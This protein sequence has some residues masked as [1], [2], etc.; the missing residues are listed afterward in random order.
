MHFFSIVIPIYNEKE[1]IFSLIEEIN[2]NLDS[3]TYNYEILIINDCSSDLNEN[4]YKIFDELKN[5]KIFS[6]QTNLGQSYSLIS[7]IK[8]SNNNT[9]L[10]L[11]GDG[12]NN[13]IDIPKL[14]NLYFSNNQIY[15]VGGIRNK[16]K[17]SLTKLLASK[18]ANKFRKSILNDKCDDTGCALKIFD[19]KTFLKFP[20]FDG[21]HRFLPAFFLAYKKK[22]VYINVD[23]RPRLKGTSKYGIYKRLINGLRDLYKVKKIIKRLK[24]ND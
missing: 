12:Q 22:S 11:D 10:T 5:T 7:G 18:I 1:N 20:E 13:P 2:Q 3:E 8:K 14:V 9:I 23:H 21:L 6:N 15:M 17:D 16:R 4:D 19:K 24:L